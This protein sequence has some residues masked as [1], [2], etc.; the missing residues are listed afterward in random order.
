THIMPE[1]I[2]NWFEKFGYGE[3]ITLQH[4]KPCC[5][6][7]IKGDKVFREIE[8]NCWDAT[9]RMKEMD[10]TEVGMQ[11]LSTIP[12]LFNYWAKPAHALESARF[13]TDHIASC[14][15]QHPD[16]FIGIGTLPMQDVDMAV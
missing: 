16:R 9:V 5:A 1:N 14:A 11:V 3:F 12:V 10:T 6:K 7:M 15:E 13:F 8:A 4:H 2:P